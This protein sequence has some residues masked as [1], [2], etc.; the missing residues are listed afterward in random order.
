MGVVDPVKLVIE[1]FPEGETEWLDCRYHPEDEAFGT[2]KVPLTRELFI[3]RADFAKDPPKKWFRL[4][5]GRE[6]AF[7]DLGKPHDFCVGVGHGG[8]R[9]DAALHACTNDAQTDFAI[10]LP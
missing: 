7:P 5:P 4:A 2:R 10:A 6:V 3:E 9:K 1:N 8:N